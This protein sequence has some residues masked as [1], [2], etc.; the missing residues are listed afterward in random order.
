MTSEPPPS[1]SSAPTAA[2]ATVPGEASLASE[3]WTRFRSNRM[4]MAGLWIVGLMFAVAI[5]APFIASNRPYYMVALKRSLAPAAAPAEP[6]KPEPPRT[7][8]MTKVASFPLLHGLTKE[9]LRWLMY[10]AAGLAVWLFRRRLTARTGFIAVTAAVAII[11]ITV[12]QHK[13]VMDWTNYR[14]IAAQTKWMP[15]IPYGPLEQESPQYEPPGNTNWMGT[16]DLGRDILSRL[17]HATRISMTVGFVATSISITLGVLVGALAGYYRGWV[18]IGL[19]RVI[20]VMECFPTMFLI[21]A[22]LAFL[23]PSLFTLMAVMGLTSWTGTARL[24]RGEFLRLSELPFALAARALGAGDRRII[25]GHILPNAMGPVLVAATFGIASAILV[26][27]SLSFLG[28]GVQPPTPTW[29]DMLSKA[30]SGVI[31]TWWLAVFPGIMIFI[32][33]TAY[34]LVGQGIRD[35]TDPRLRE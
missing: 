1:I 22:V 19:S 8:V 14:A 25:L 31:S 20:E 34:N 35:A 21:L 13:E 17:I 18:D 28:M 30:R 7:V 11:E 15:P 23:T 6:G 5:F 10:P 16:D 24:V 9:D 27:S 33:I 2:A 3:S 29:G 26:E 12:A 4:A 32:S